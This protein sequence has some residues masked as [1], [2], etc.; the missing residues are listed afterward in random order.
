MAVQQLKRQKS[1]PRKDLR[2]SASQKIVLL[3]RPPASKAKPTRDAAHPSAAEP[4]STETEVLRKPK[5]HDSEAPAREQ[6]SAYDGDT[7]IKLYLRE[8]GLVK[9]L[10]P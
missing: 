6:R 4:P 3:R 5:A 1:K 9:L 10:T 7:A 2:R 8:I